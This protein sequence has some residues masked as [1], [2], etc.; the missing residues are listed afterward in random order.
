V[1]NTSVAGDEPAQFYEPAFQTIDRLAQTGGSPSWLLSHHPLWAF[2][3]PPQVV[4]ATLQEASGHG[5]PPQVALAVAGHV[6]LFEVLGF[7][8]G[9]VPSLVLGTGG[10]AMVAPIPN[11]Q[12]EALDGQQVENAATWAKF[13]YA[14]AEPGASGWTIT[15]YS[16]ED[17]SKIVCRVAGTSLDCG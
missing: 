10:S 7:D 11:P 4:T 8:S 3:S 16:V 6:H 2:N 17:D 9:R 1:L 12:G 14:I 13:G 5:L 15:V